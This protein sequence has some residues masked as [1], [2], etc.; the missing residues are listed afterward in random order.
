MNPQDINPYSITQ[1]YLPFNL[2]DFQVSVHNELAPLRR[3]GYYLDMGLGKSI[4]STASAL[5]KLAQGADQVLVLMPPILIP[6]W[7]RLLAKIKE[8]TCLAYRG[9]PAERRAMKLDKDFILMSYQIF[10]KD[11]ER[12]AEELS[13]KR[14]VIIADEADAL[15]NVGSDNHRKFNT[16]SVGHDIMLLT[17]TPLSTPV[18]GYAFIKMVA[19]GTY[20]NMNHF[21]N[22]HVAQR[23]FF[24]NITAWQNLDIL[25]R[26]MTINAKRILKEEVLKELPGITHTPLYYDLAPDHYK[27]Y[28]RLANEHLLR[29]EEGGKIDATTPQALYHALGQIVSNYD[30]FSG[31]PSNESQNIELIHELMT[32]LGDKKLIVFTNYR[33]T[34]RMLQVRLA[35]YNPVAVFGDVSRKEQEA[36][37]QTFIN[38]PKCRLI[39][40]QVRAGGVGIDGLQHVCSDVLFLE[41]PPVPAWFH[42]AAARAHRV[43][44]ENPVHVRIAVAEG[45]CNVRQFNDLM[46]KDELVGKVMPNIRD[47]RDSVF[48]G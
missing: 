7:A 28:M 9:T 27:L 43:G 30:Y 1:P 15:K 25:K 44:Q 12:L 24:N 46:N 45:T 48:G 42:Q 2:Y 39:Q 20:R 35:R 11:F 10:K 18:D 22:V 19:P 32:E 13:H 41:I 5:W 36:A 37:L 17:G 4:T 29:L 40:L 33:I 23:D 38:D 16:F 3:A 21:Y 8:V 34:N 47:L 14:L 26:N 6:G 31:D